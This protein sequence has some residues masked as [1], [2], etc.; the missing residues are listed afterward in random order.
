MAS[1]AHSG[2]ADGEWRRIPAGTAGARAKPVNSKTGAR[3]AKA[4]EKTVTLSDVLNTFSEHER[5]RARLAYIAERVESITQ[6]WSRQDLSDTRAALGVLHELAKSLAAP[7][8]CRSAQETLLYAMR[9]YYAAMEALERADL[10]GSQIDYN[11]ACG[12]VRDGDVL[13]ALAMELAS[14]A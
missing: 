8:G 12:C 13:L 14:E 9:S 2:V 4:W 1:G 6:A 5:Y 11:A 3:R 10:T 7:P